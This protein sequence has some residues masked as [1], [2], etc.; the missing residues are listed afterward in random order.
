[1]AVD[2]QQTFVILKAGH[3]GLPQSRYRVIV[4]ACK[5]ERNLPVYPEPLHGIFNGEIGVKIDDKYN[6][7]NFQ[8]EHSAPFVYTTV[9][10]AIEDITSCKT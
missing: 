4:M 1:M 3:Y 6:E 5:L 7:S 8:N 9:R 10:D 2:Y